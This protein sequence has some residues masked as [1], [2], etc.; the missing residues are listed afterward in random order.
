MDS[1]RTVVMGFGTLL[2]M[3]MAYLIWSNRGAVAGAIRGS[4][5]DPKSLVHQFAKSW[6]A[7]AT[8]YLF[9]I[10][11]F[12]FMVFAVLRREVKGAFI[13]SLRIVP[14][15]LGVDR[16][17]QWLVNAVIESFRQPSPIPKPKNIFGKPEDD[18]PEGTASESPYVALVKKG[19]RLI[20]LLAVAFWFLDV[21]GVGLTFAGTLAGAAFNVFVTILAAYL[22]WIWCS[23][24]IDRRILKSMKAAEPESPEKEEDEWGHAATQNRFY[25]LMPL[26]RKTL[27]TVLVIMVTLIS[28]SAIGVDIGPLLA[29]AGVVGLAIGFGAQR[30]VRDILSGIFFLLDDAFRVGE[31]V[32]LGSVSGTVEELTLRLVKLRH[33]RGMLQFVPYGDIKQVTNSIRGGIV[34]KFNLEFPYDT[35]ID[36]VRRIIKK[37]GQGMLEEKEFAPDFIR[38]LKSQGVREIGDSI[39]TIRVKFTARPGAHFVIRREA[40]RRITAALMKKGIHYATRKFI[41]DLPK[42]FFQQRF[43]QIPAPSETSER[44]ESLEAPAE[45][46]EKPVNPV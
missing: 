41:V 26:F 11:L 7:F 2:L 37:V 45:D 40:Y 35:D 46:L 20:V 4:Q 22:V 19:T 34:V 33:H 29:G 36:L 17:G 13:L 8:A 9:V 38:P 42:E 6:H 43:Q 14:I 44:K 16:L 1:W 5:P 39:M 3:L 32:E 15:Y 28:L 21:W 24:A 27:A 31:Y 30:L 12:G 25:T 18:L 23:R 10:W